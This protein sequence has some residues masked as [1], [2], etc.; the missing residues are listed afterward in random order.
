MDKHPWCRNL[1]AESS[2]LDSLGTDGLCRVCEEIN[3]PNLMRHHCPNHEE[4]H[5]HYHIGSF[6][7]LR[8]KTFCPGCRL[9]RHSLESAGSKSEIRAS[10]T[11]LN[12][13]SDIILR[14]ISLPPIDL[15]E[16]PGDFRSMRSCLGMFEVVIG[17][18]DNPIV[19]GTIFQT[20]KTHLEVSGRLIELSGLSADYH[21]VCGQIISPSI[22]IDL[23]RTWRQHCYAH[24]SRC[25]SSRVGE[26]PEGQG[27]RLIDVH[28]LKVIHTAT[29]KKFLALSY[30]WGP[31]ARPL[32]THKTMPGYMAAGGLKDPK[33]G[34]R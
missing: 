22:E 21:H 30:V 4:D 14:R 9:I 20:S 1:R 11:L 33:R 27:I 17:E 34:G 18:L 31:K 2:C 23:I 25:L 19:V 3:L 6:E 32:L 16:V 10:A 12:P 5:F 13:E 28:E 29:R 24:H 7:N 26:L 8:I 15:D